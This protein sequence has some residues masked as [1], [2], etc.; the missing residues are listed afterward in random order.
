MAELGAV[1]MV[2]KITATPPSSTNRRAAS[3]VDAVEWHVA[4]IMVPTANIIEYSS[5]FSTYVTSADEFGAV[6]PCQRQMRDSR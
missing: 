4:D 5:A 3:I 1:P 2:A 6:D